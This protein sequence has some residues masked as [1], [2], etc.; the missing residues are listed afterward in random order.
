[1]RA[2]SHQQV[3]AQPTIETQH[4][5]NTS[6]RRSFPDLKHPHEG[7][8]TIHWNS[9]R[10]NA[11]L[12]SSNRIAG[13]PRSTVQPMQCRMETIRDA[14]PIAYSA[15]KARPVSREQLTNSPL[16]ERSHPVARRSVPHRSGFGRGF[17]RMPLLPA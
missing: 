2:I 3:V 12:M 1:M 10:E 17:L 8:G 7:K 13:G 6:A 4:S 11:A 14:K 15:W 5:H 16:S 9:L